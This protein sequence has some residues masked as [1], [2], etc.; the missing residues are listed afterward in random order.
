LAKLVDEHS[1]LVKVCE[2]N[3]QGLCVEAWYRLLEKLFD[4]WYVE[5]RKAINALEA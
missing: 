3:Y 2:L 1:E 5:V 4:R